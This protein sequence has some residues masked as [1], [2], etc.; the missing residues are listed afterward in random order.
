MVNAH[1][2][3]SGGRLETSGFC[4]IVVGLKLCSDTVFY[5]WLVKS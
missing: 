5:D 4:F 1:I 3:D 2:A